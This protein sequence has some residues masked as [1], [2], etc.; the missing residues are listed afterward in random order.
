M[1]SNN[2]QDKSASSYLAIIS[3][4]LL[5]FSVSLTLYGFFSNFGITD[6]EGFYLY[7]LIHAISETSFTFFHTGI[8]FIGTLFNHNLLGYRILNLLLILTSLNIAAYN[9][10][11]FYFRK[12][13][14]SFNSNSNLKL[15][16]TRFGGRFRW[17][18]TKRRGQSHKRSGPADCAK[19]LESAAPC[20]QGCWP[21]CGLHRTVLSSSKSP[22]TP[23]AFRRDPSKLIQN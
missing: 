4:I 15:F 17:Q 3:Y 14:S 1:S 13:D 11:L 12:N 7:F 6:D 20:L 19:R 16:F 9:S 8:H 2:N 22:Q 23:R 10:F 18:S 21:C 5:I